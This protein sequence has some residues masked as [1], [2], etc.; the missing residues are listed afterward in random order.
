[1]FPHAQLLNCEVINVGCGLVNGGLR[2]RREVI[3]QPVLKHWA[4]IGLGVQ[5]WLI[6]ISVCKE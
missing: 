3:N 4:S 2:L 5:L 6:V 1:M